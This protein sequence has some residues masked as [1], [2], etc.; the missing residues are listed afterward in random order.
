MN[1][2]I[3]N[4]TEKPK[5]IREWVLYTLQQICSV[6]VATLLIAQICGTPYSSCLLGACIG[7]IIYQ[8]ITKFRSPMFISSCGATCSAVI[9][10]LSLPAVSDKNYIMVAFGGLITAIIYII[11]ATI[12]KFGGVDKL[13]N[14]FP[15]AIV[16][17][18][19]M[20]IGL[21]LATFLPTYT[22][23]S[24]T[25]EVLIAIIVMIVIAITSHYFTGFLKTIPFL[26][27]LGVGYVLC[28][29]LTV[30]GIAP[31]IDWSVFNPSTWE[32]YPD[33]TFLKWNFE[34][35]TWTNIVKTI[36]LF[37][38]VSICAL[39][40]HYS[41]H[42]CLSNIVGH[43]LTTDPGL[44]RT[45]IG[46]GVASFIGTCTAGLPNTSYGESIA[47][48]GFS[49]V[50]SVAVITV[51]AIVLGIM[52]FFAPLTAVISSIPSC[53]FGGA[54]MVLYGYITASGLKLIK[55]SGINLE[56]N[57]NL[58]IISVVLT[59]GVGGIFL[60]SDSFAG[61][62]LAMVLG[63]ILNLILKNKNKI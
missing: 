11:F 9:G 40:E 32:W 41:D 38:P 43:D 58:I 1:N 26:L 34:D 57:K 47:C 63:V 24:S 29:I 53:V 54:S 39:L 15:P 6:I 12:V 37:V 18:V 21:N 27:G 8:L 17:A 2:M 51:S 33:V 28:V 59:T 5:K 61:V 23:N 16:G 36:V 13:N 30:T 4:I 19:T 3:Y 62:S 14:L 22:H 31:L 42:R 56:D 60:F 7:T 50:A 55:N 35:I 48:I 10:A 25:W 20:V 49:K 46:D 52:S 45:L 44:H